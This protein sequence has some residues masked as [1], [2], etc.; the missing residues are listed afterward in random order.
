MQTTEKSCNGA[1]VH[2]DEKTCGEFSVFGASKT[3][4]V[5]IAVDRSEHADDFGVRVPKRREVVV[6]E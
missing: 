2:D 6:Y 3:T 5:E 1:D 4:H